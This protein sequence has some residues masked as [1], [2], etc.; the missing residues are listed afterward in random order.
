MEK[1][2]IVFLYTELATYFLACVD[3]LLKHSNIEVYIIRY[4]VNKEAPF[5][6]SFSENIKMYNRNDFVSVVEMQKLIS[7][8]NPSIIYCSGWTDKSYLN[9]CKRYK[10]KIP[11]IVGFDNQWKGSLKQQIAR[12]ISPFK[13]LNHFYIVGYQVNYKKSMLS[14]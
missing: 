4:A 7:E 6:F 13:I 12:L 9:I 14:Y 2:K 11:V 3:S 5:Q 8:I 1:R 10:N